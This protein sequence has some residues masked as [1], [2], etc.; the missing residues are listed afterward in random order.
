MPKITL[1]KEDIVGGPLN[2][3][4]Y[5]LLLFRAEVAEADRYRIAKYVLPLIDKRLQEIEDAR[6]R[7]GLSAFDPVNY[8][9]TVRDHEAEIDAQHKLRNEYGP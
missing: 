2:E 8:A 5:E 6:N 1:T 4:Q 3:E 7:A 9:E